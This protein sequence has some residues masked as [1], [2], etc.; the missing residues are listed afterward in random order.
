QGA[1][2]ASGQFCVPDV[3]WAGRGYDNPSRPFLTPA[4]RQTT[5][6]PMNIT[7]AVE[8]LKTLFA[9]SDQPIFLQTL[10]N[11][12]DDPDE[13]PNKRHL[14]SRDIAAIERFVAKH[15]RARRG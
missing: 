9:D 15:N 5:G 6:I 13:G 8:F 7:P 4:I 2:L 3:V 12:P 1:H 14:L 11:D 10:A